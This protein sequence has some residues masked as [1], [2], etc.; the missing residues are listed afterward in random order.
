[1]ERKRLIWGLGFEEIGR[2]MCKSRATMDAGSN[3]LPSVW[4]NVSKRSNIHRL[5]NEIREYTNYDE[6]SYTLQ[7]DFANMAGDI[8]LWVWSEVEQG[9]RNRKEN[10]FERMMIEAFCENNDSGIYIL[11]CHLLGHTV[12]DARRFWILSVWDSIPY[13][14]FHMG[15]K[16]V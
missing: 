14:H 6:H 16:L 12:K 7:K 5:K 1:M 3:G 13:E 11:S 10:D 2:N 4:E 8:D 15:S 9:S